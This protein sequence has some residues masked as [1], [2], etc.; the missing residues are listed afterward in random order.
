MPKASNLKSQKEKSS[1]G[2]F[3]SSM[4]KDISN[5]INFSKLSAGEQFEHKA[6][7]EVY[8]RAAEDRAAYYDGN[9][10]PRQAARPVGPPPPPPIKTVDQFYAELSNKD[11]WGALPSLGMKRGNVTAP[12]YGKVELKQREGGVV[13]SLFNPYD[14]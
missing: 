6:K 3:F 2:S 13:R 5:T 10:E 9:D 8:R 12:R 1:V 11:L 4:A 14:E 7:T